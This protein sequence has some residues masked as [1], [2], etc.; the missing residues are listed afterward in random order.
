[1]RENV[2]ALLRCMH[3]CMRRTHTQNPSPEHDKEYRHAQSNINESWI[4]LARY[5]QIRWGQL[6]DIDVAYTG[7]D[8]ETCALLGGSGW[9]TMTTKS[10]RRRREEHAE[11][12]CHHSVQH[13]L[14]NMSLSSSGLATRCRL[15]W[16]MNVQ[17]LHECGHRCNLKFD[18]AGALVTGKKLHNEHS[19]MLTIHIGSSKPNGRCVD[20]C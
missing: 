16:T 19:T 4:W 7:V 5:E 17:E 2:L 11:A 9:K 8:S 3:K 1:M 10:Y 20:D 6:T 18:V 12:S 15:P 13:N 14:A